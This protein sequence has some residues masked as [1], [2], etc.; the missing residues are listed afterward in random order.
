MQETNDD[1]GSTGSGNGSGGIKIEQGGYYCGG[2]GSP[3]PAPPAP[4]ATFDPDR[5]TPQAML[6]GG[7]FSK[8]SVFFIFETFIFCVSLGCECFSIRSSA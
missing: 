4:P 1:T 2:Y 3:A 7:C 5:S 6:V 8:F